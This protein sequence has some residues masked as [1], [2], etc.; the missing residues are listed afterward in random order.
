M[1]MFILLY[2]KPMGKKVYRLY[3]LAN[4][5]NFAVLYL[6]ATP[7]LLSLKVMYEN[8]FNERIGGE[9]MTNH[10]ALI[11]E[12]KDQQIKQLKEALLCADNIVKAWENLPGDRNYP[13][14][15]VANW[16]LNEM[17]PAINE[18]RNQKHRFYEEKI[19]P[20][21]DAELKEEALSL[22]EI[23]TLSEKISKHYDTNNSSE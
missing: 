16:L 8:Q 13:T 4:K 12:S 6:F 5:I 3:H 2:L 7:F 17:S 21:T 22:R 18:Y 15:V 1:E 9:K 20:K 23:K 14:K 10:E 11:I 19:F